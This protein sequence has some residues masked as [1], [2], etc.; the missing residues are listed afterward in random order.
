MADGTLIFDTKI[1]NSGVK[2]S[3]QDIKKQVNS[4]RKTL[5][6]KQ[7]KPRM[8]SLKMPMQHQGLA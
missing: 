5:S 8:N 6:S 3:L 4:M 1:D 2:K 7:F